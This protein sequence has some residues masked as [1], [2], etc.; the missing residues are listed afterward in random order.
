[1][2]KYKRHYYFLIIRLFC[3]SRYRNLIILPNQTIH[4]GYTS[5]DT[6]FLCVFIFKIR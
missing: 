3:G 5:Y 2:F 6:G 1:M 4:I